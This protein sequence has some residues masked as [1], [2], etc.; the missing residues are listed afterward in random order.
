MRLEGRL[1]R[2]VYCRLMRSVSGEMQ[3]KQG[4]RSNAAGCW[5]SSWEEG[6]SYKE[7]WADATELCP[8]AREPFFETFV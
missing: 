8:R 4:V 5:K 1:D 6:P 3:S 7:W 2:K